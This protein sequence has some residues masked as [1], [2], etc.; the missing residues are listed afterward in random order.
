MI[1]VIRII[2]NYLRNWRRRRVVRG[3]VVRPRVPR[4]RPMRAV[5]AARE[6]VRWM[7]AGSEVMR[8]AG[9]AGVPGVRRA[10]GR[11]ARPDAAERTF[12]WNPVSD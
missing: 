1:Y 3:P 4:R 5:G 12:Y 2:H 10:Q 11:T 7:A 6:T 8:R 9:G